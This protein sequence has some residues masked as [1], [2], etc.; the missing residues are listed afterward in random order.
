LTPLSPQLGDIFGLT[1]SAVSK[2]M[3]VLKSKAADDKLI[4]K[5]LAKIK[6]LIQI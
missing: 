6:S 2:R 5:K 4:R 1:G 3:A